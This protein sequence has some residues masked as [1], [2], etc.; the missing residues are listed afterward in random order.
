MRPNQF[1]QVVGESGGAI[2][3]EPGRTCWR[4]ADASRA[5]VLV[6]GAEYFAALEEALR[7]ARHSITIL[8]WAFDGRIRLRP[9]VEGSPALGQ[10]LREQVEK[11]PQLQVR[12]LVWSVAI[13]HAPGATIP[14]LFGAEWDDHPRIQV[15]LDTRHPIYGA[16]HQ[17]VVCVDD[18]VAFAGGTDLTIERWDRPAHD[19]HDPHRVTPDGKRYGPVHDLQMLVEGDAAR[20]LADFA[21]ERWKAATGETI[22]PVHHEPSCWP[23][24][25]APHFEEV[26]V[27]LARTAAG[28]GRTPPAREAIALTIAAIDAAREVIY[29]EAQYLTARRVGR[30]LARSLEKPDGPQVVIVLTHCMHG[31]VEAWIMGGN[32]DRLVRRLRRRDR[33]G[34][35]RIYHPVRPGGDGW[36][37]VLIHAKLV[38]VDDVFIRVGSSNLN[39]RSIG[40]DTECDVAI[41]SRRPQDRAQ[42]AAIRNGLIGEHI[43]RDVGEVGAAIAQA[44]SVIA[45]IEQLN[46]GER[47]LRELEVP[48]RRTVFWQTLGT[49]LLDPQKPFEPWWFLKRRQRPDTRARR[50]VR[51]FS[52]IRPR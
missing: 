12:V 27:A 4:T 26:P 23:E 36:C 34:R 43:G 33:H 21:R 25:V 47:H 39:N 1:D 11:H 49:R 46:T 45:G 9:D 13:A 38:V 30:A 44:G 52:P 19:E 50:L 37:D 8:G 2:I 40:L 48:K 32:R 31:A 28:W 41:E 35:L 17:K 15:R 51:R 42:I 7:C 22:H 20:V 24:G 18:D 3:C 5:R 14:L 16:H 29:I 10:I 6:D